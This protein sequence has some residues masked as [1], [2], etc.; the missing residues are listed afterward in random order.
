MKNTLKS[1]KSSQDGVVRWSPVD[2]QYGLL[3]T[4]VLEACIDL[5]SCHHFT[6]QSCDGL[7]DLNTGDEWR[8][9][10]L[11]SLK[12]FGVLQFHSNAVLPAGN[13]TGRYA[14]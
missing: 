8:F 1:R 6:T 14:F 5:S 3:S 11:L 7:E 9:Y 2:N 13:L 4:P 12:A 10:S